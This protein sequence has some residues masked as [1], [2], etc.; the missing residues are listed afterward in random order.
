MQPALVDGV[1]PD[2]KRRCW[3]HSHRTEEARKRKGQ[4]LKLTMEDRRMPRKSKKKAARKDEEK[5]NGWT[6][7]ATFQEPREG[8]IVLVV[9]AR[10]KTLASTFISFALKQGLILDSYES[11]EDS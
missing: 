7:T 11:E 6:H 8:K 3:S 4:K 2:G 10:S 9:G 5:K 1:D